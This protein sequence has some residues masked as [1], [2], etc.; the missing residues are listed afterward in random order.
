MR[1]KRTAIAA[2]VVLSTL[3]AFV[4]TSRIDEEPPGPMLDYGASGC[5][6]KPYEATGEFDWPSLEGWAPAYRRNLARDGADH[7]LLCQATGFEGAGWHRPLQITQG[8]KEL[9]RILGGLPRAH[10][11][12]A[13]LLIDYAPVNLVLHYPDGRRTVM[14]FEFNRDEVSTHNAIRSGAARLTR[15]FARLWRTEHTSSDP[16]TIEP[17]ACLPRQ[18]DVR[19]RRLDH[20][21]PNIVRGFDF[22]ENVPGYSNVS[23]LPS[24]LAVVRA[25]RYTADDRGRLVLRS[26]NDAR[27]DLESLRTGLNVVK[28]PEK[29]LP[30]G[31]YES[32]KITALDTLHL[33]DVTG[34]SAHVYIARRPCAADLTPWLTGDG[35]VAPEISAMLSRLLD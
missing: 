1:F 34:R 8:V 18:P 13:S 28:R 29:R 25:C 16:S 9:Q 19:T 5:P 15:E 32:P 3:G 12:G 14:S 11:G 4:A 7:A 27:T 30:C 20:P 23:K 6:A 21:A 35:S 33:T 31:D 2:T 10:Y 17:A 22:Y 24:P 26:Q